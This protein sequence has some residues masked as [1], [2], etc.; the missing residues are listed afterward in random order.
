MNR[1]EFMDQLARLL[2]DLPESDREDAIA[3]YND[4]FDEAG[5]ENEGEVIQE[6]GSPGKVAATIM[7]G[8]GR[9]SSRGEYTE[10]GY[11]D[12][13][14]KERM[15]VPADRKKQ[16]GQKRGAGRWALLIILIV[17]ASPMLLGVG[18]GLL[19][20]ILGI[21]GAM[22]G[23]VVGVFAGGIGCLAGGVASVAA[24]IV[25][26]FTNPGA[27]LMMIGSGMIAVAAGLLFA[28]FFLW[29]IFTVLPRLFRSV[30][31]WCSRILHRGREGKGNEENI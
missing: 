18:G 4:Y 19:G 20:V 7:A 27:G 3:Y 13:R 28:I 24:G 10:Q 16:D 12:S 14:F 8:M 25:R 9:D 5:E 6:L 15:Q 30:I 23:V 11:Q 26:C 1:K 31:N 17:F 29:L 21:L 2:S 22:L